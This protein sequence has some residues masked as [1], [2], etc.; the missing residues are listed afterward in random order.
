[1]KVRLAYPLPIQGQLYTQLVSGGLSKGPNDRGDAGPV[2]PLG[3][4]VLRTVDRTDL[5][6][7]RSLANAGR[8]GIY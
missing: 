4:H 2:C 8:P 5:T 6:E 7:P 1:M 3:S